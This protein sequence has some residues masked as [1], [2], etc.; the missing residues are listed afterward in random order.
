MELL[1]ADQRDALFDTFQRD[2]FHL[3]LRDS[4]AVGSEDDS[5][6]RWKRGEPPDPAD[7]DR[8]W[9]QRIKR[10]TQ[11]GRTIRRVRVIMEPIS[12]YIHFEYDST[13]ENLAAGED[14]RWLPRRLVPAGVVFPLEG[15][16][17]W[18]FDDSLVAV[19][20]FDDYGRPLG[21]RV[22]TDPVLLSQCISVRDRLWLSAIP[23]TDYQPR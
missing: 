11:R 2:A 9:L 21:S 3:E 15:R 16:D 23:H 17:W 5:Y 8:P 10:I 19:G 13:P 22:S 7:R 4:Y 20:E 14:I 18:L 12:E 1:T 6:Q